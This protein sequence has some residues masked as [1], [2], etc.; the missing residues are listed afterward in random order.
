MHIHSGP[1]PSA[2]RCVC[3]GA[4]PVPLPVVAPPRQR[5]AA[6][7]APEQ[8]CWLAGQCGRAAGLRP[9]FLLVRWIAES[10]ACMLLGHGSCGLALMGHHCAHSVVKHG[11]AS[12]KLNLLF[13]GS[14]VPSMLQMC[15]GPPTWRTTPARVCKLELNRCIHRT[16]CTLFYSAR[17]SGMAS[18]SAVA[19]CCCLMLHP[20]LPS[21]LV[22]RLQPVDGTAPGSRGGLGE[23][24]AWRVLQHA[25]LTHHRMQAV[26]QCIHGR[27]GLHAA[28]CNKVAMA[29]AGHH[30]CPFG[31]PAAG[32]SPFDAAFPATSSAVL[33]ALL[34]AHGLVLPPRRVCAAPRP[35]HS[36]PGALPHVA[37]I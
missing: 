36:V 35:Q 32:A 4:A 33:L 8:P 37:V 28:S 16:L 29:M 30:T 1:S 15:C 18:A 17:R 13:A 20:L 21:A 22:C 3:Q 26:R 27:P 10:C 14:T 12:S 19:L 34:P 24:G 5:P 11:C 7:A 9:G 25:Q 23:V 31:Q 2:C 6:V